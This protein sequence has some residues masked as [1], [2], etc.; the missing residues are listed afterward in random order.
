MRQIP[1]KMKLRE[2][3]TRNHHTRKIKLEYLNPDITNKENIMPLEDH[4]G[5]DFTSIKGKIASNSKLEAIQAKK[6]FAIK[7]QPA[8]NSVVRALF[9]LENDQG[10]ENHISVTT[11]KTLQ[12]NGEDSILD[13]EKSQMILESSLKNHLISPLLRAKMVNWM[14]EVLTTFN[15]SHN[16]FFLSVA[17]MD[18]YYLKANALVKKVIFI[19]LV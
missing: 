18:R 5:N 12:D 1:K 17:I 11:L 9:T 13:M 4:N 8:N 10:I 19:L 3:V 15:L 14:I 7:Q 16:T 6:I 2:G